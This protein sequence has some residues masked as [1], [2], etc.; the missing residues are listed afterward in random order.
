MLLGRHN[1]YMSSETG[2]IFD[3]GKTSKM[4]DDIAKEE[5]YTP[6]IGLYTKEQMR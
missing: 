3:N 2:Q 6:Y 1:I 4:G 5:K